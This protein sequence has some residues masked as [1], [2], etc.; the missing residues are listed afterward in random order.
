MSAL[1]QVEDLS[2]KLQVEGETREVLTSVSLEIAAGEAMG[3]VGESGSGKSM[4]AKAIARLLPEGA[5]VSGRLSF[6]GRDVLTLTGAELRA[7]RAEVAVIFQ[8]PRAHINPVRRIDDFMGGIAARAQEFLGLR[9]QEEVRAGVGGSGYRQSR[10][11][12]A[13]V[14]TRIVGRNVAARDDRNCPAH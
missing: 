1:L 6:D 11:A 10:K 12:I 13:A 9:C 5:L 14:P 4:T 7:H 3:L 8:D 2:V